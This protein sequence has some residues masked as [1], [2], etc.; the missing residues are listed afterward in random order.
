M[1]SDQAH[2]KKRFIYSFQRQIKQHNMRQ[3]LI[4]PVRRRRPR[5]Q[6]PW[7]VEED[8]YLVLARLTLPDH[9]SDQMAAILN[10]Y[11][12]CTRRRLSPQRNANSVQ[13]RYDNHIRPR[14]GVNQPAHTGAW[15]WIRDFANFEELT[16][17]RDHLRGRYAGFG[18]PV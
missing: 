1:A 4:P 9:S 12:C 5:P 8:V 15:S 14:N 3:S 17:I 7:I 16:W 11:A 18:F 6:L 13:N 10:D 2:E